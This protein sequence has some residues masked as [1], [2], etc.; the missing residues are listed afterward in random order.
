MEDLIG[1]LGGFFLEHYSISSSITFPI[2]IIIV[3]IDR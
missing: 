1:G 3:Q 2:L